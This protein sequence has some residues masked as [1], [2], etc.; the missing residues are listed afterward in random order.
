[1]RNVLVV[2]DDPEINQL[3]G[4]YVEIAG[5]GY[6]SALDG[7]TALRRARESN[8]SLIVLDLML[9]DTDGIEVCRQL[10]SDSRTAGIPVVMLTAMDKEEHGRR[11]VACGAAAYMTKPFDPDALLEMIQKNAV[12]G[13]PRGHG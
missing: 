12:N 6:E 3:V 7:E 2:D 10:K 11:G 8:P 1:M 4:A 13:H 9:P 5:F